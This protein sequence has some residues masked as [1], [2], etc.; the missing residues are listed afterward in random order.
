[1]GKILTVKEVA[2]LLGLSEPAVRMK[3]RR[4]QLP[5]RKMGQRIVFL[6]D[7]LLIFIEGLPPVNPKKSVYGGKENE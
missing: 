2:K 5:A 1:M 6:Q 3:I 7:E 4:G